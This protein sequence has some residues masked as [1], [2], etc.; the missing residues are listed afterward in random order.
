MDHHTPRYTELIAQVPMTNPP[1]IKAGDGPPT[2]TGLPHSAARWWVRFALQ[3]HT[4]SISAVGL[5]LDSRHG[6][7]TWCRFITQGSKAERRPFAALQ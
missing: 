4:I 3:R 5:S 7:L 2:Q 1:S 6:V